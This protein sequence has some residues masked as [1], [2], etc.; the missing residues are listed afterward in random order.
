MVCENESDHEPVDSTIE[1]DGSDLI[2]ECKNC[3]KPIC[4]GGVVL[5]SVEGMWME[6]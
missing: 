4:G 5:L 6:Y 2:A 1:W 3:G